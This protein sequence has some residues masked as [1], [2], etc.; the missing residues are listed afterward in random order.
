MI[1]GV[2]PVAK[3]IREIAMWRM[4]AEILRRVP[5]LQVRE[6]FSTDDPKAGLRGEDVYDCVTL[7][8]TEGRSPLDRIHFDRTLGEIVELR[9]GRLAEQPWPTYDYLV[10]HGDLASVL[11]HTLNHME[12]QP[13]VSYPLPPSTRTVLS[14]RFIASLLANNVFTNRTLS[15]RSGE[16]VTWS[17]T[18]YT[19][20]TYLDAMPAAGSRGALSELWFVKW[21]GHRD[22]PLLAI[23]SGNG[24]VHDLQGETHDLME[25]YNKHGRHLPPVVAELAD[26][27]PKR[28]V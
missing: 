17:G 2:D 22:E 20:S 6:T 8:E 26:A 16:Y 15:C 4:V 24:L 23:D 11:T 21:F 19:R 14:F 1:E 10:A 27:L 13:E 28:K 5:R 7:I 3:P 25:L 12:L 18:G 9:T